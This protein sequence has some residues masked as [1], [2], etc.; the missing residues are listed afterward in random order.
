MVTGGGGGGGGGVGGGGDVVDL[1]LVGVSIPG[2]D[3]DEAWDSIGL[4]PV[5]GLV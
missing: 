2:I 5:S 4:A 3:D 1:C